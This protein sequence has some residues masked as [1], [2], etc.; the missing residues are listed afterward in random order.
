VITEERFMSTISLER[1]M[2]QVTGNSVFERTQNH[3]VG[4]A[5]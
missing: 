4:R 2:I 1:C 5:K 3:F